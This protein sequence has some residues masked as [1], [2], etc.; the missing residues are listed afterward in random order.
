[1]ISLLPTHI[2]S[3]IFFFVKTYYV[4]CIIFYWKRYIFYKKYIFFY[5]RTLPKY[6]SF[7]D[8][9]LVLD[10]CNKSTLFF[11]KKLFFLTTG[12]ESYFLSIYKLYYLLAVSIDDYEWSSGR[13]NYYYYYNKYYCI[14]IASKFSWNNILKM[15]T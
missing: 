10:V 7:I 2:I 14:L 9:D 4:N 1:M 13:Y 11:F 6:Y 5:I 15:L 12:K 8:Y 3:R